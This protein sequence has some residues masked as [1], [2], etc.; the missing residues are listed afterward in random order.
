[1]YTFCGATIDALKFRSCYGRRTANWSPNIFGTG[2][3][4]AEPNTLFPLFRASSKQS[5]TALCTHL[6]LVGRITLGPN[7]ITLESFISSFCR[8]WEAIRCPTVGESPGSVAHSDARSTGDRE[9]VSSRLRSG[10]ILSVRLIMNF[11]SMVI[12]S[13]P[14]IQEGKLSVT[15][16]RMCTEY[17]ITA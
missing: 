15:C 9:V 2:V 6:N 4:K 3:G 11:F 16:E 17:W 8:P 13:L 14:L 5:W 1:M 10:P 7:G 12:L